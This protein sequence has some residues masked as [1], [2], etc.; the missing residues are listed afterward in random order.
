M[1]VWDFFLVFGTMSQQSAR[2]A[3]RQELPGHLPQPATGQSP[4]E[5][6]RPQSRPIRAD[7]RRHHPRAAP[8]IRRPRPLKRASPKQSRNRR[9]ASN[10]RHPALDALSRSSSSPSISPTSRLL[11]LPYFWDEAG[12][13]I[14]AAWDF[15]R[16]G[17]L[18]PQTTVTNAHPPLPSILL[19]AWWHL[20]GYV[21]SGTRTLVCM[22]SAAA[23]LGRL[24]TRQNP[25]QHRGRRSHRHPHRDLPH[26]VRAKHPRPRRHLRRRLHPL[27]TLLLLRPHT[28][29]TSHQKHST[30]WPHSCSPSPPSP[31]R[32]PSSRRALS[33][34][35]KPSYSS[36]IAQPT[37]RRTHLNWLVAL[38][39]PILPLAAWYAYHY[40]Q[41][42]FVFGN[43]EFLRYNATANLDAY[44]IAALPLASPPPPHHP[45]EHVRPGRLHHRGL[46]HPRHS[47]RTAAQ[48]HSLTLKAIAVVLLANWIAFSIL[49]GALLTRYLLPMYPLILL[50]CVSHLASPSPPDGGLSPPSRAAA[51]LAG[52]WINPPYAFAPEDNLTYRDMIVLHQQAVRFIDRAVSRR[53]PSSP[54]GPPPPN[55]PAPNSATPTT[56]SRS[57]PSK[58][59][60]STR[61][62]RPPP[63]PATTTSP[64]SSPPSGSRRQS[65]Q[66][67]QAATNPPT[68]N[69][70]TSTTT[71]PPPKPPPCS[72][73]KSSGRPSRKGEWAAVLHFPRIVERSVWP[74]LRSTLKLYT[75]ML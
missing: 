61:S 6:A 41:T 26:L 13:Y 52:I 34:S 35:G 51:F 68:Q 19:A 57:S 65:A 62:R 70:S 67:R 27:G 5:R 4:L 75:H 3:H 46:L 45:H 33:P 32:Q 64:S 29:S 42:G 28:N 37:L 48:F 36:A 55:S 71:S 9:P 30:L 22:V 25:H 60:P 2:R 66:P 21:V 56:P 58:T 10:H 40:H 54:H 49:G 12:Y 47:K 72:T 38:L 69:T 8:P 59:S 1:S 17:T 63:T 44:R 15:F 20:S 74:S 14:P 16:T 24:Q 23:L 31:K 18:I 39:S 11:R 50:L 53:P 43:P 73:A 7:L